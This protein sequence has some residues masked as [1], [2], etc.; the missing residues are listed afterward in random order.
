[1]WLMTTKGRAKAAENALAACWSTG[2]RQSGIV[3]VDGEDTAAYDDIK[4]PPNWSM[5]KWVDVGGIGNL[6]GSKQYVFEHYPDERVYGWMADDNIPVTENWSYKIEELAYPWRLVHCRDM[7]ISEE[8]LSSLDQLK[9]T[10]NLGGGICW[11]G[12]LIRCVGWWAPP[13]IIQGSIDW[14][15]TSLVGNTPLG[16]YVHDII[17]RHDNWRTGRREK[18]DNDDLTKAYIRADVAHIDQYRRT[19][20]FK[21]KKVKVLREYQKYLARGA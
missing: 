21:Q 16:L 5:V 19:P 11:G 6:A 9:R 14:A 4:L 20:E 17:V 13:G 3:F 12:E 2:M 7:W 1:M 8:S 10:I 18:D 15:W